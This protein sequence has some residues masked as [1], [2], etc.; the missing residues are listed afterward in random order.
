[1]L[2]KIEQG[3]EFSEERL[4]EDFVWNHLETALDL[5][6][7][8][9][10][11][12]IQGEYCD[13]LAKT[14]NNQ[15]VVLELKNCEDRYIIH[16]LTRY[17][18]GLKTDQPFKDL[19]DYSQ[20]IRLIAIAPDFHKHNFIDRRY[21]LLQIEFIRSV[22]LNQ[23]NHFYLHLHLEGRKEITI[24]EPIPFIEI[25]DETSEQIERNIEPP[26]R[27]LMNVLDD[28]SPS[29]KTEILKLR[30]KILGCD[31]RIRE[32]KEGKDIFYGRG[33]TKP[34]CQLK[35]I[36]PRTLIKTNSLR[37]H[38]WLPIPKSFLRFNRNSGIG[39]MFLNCDS[40]FRNVRTVTYWSPTNRNPTELPL[41]IERYLDEIGLDIANQN[42]DRLLDL[43][44]K[45]NLERS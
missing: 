7:L 26:S 5:I 37:L 8:K 36:S 12:G 35:C 28:L 15:L 21:N 13:I 30:E 10:Q 3:W 25:G 38:L 40:D 17:Y 1:M 45:V 34:C 22:I 43:A 44:I 14:A 23:T 42:L 33:K 24:Q 19:V 4:L 27:M 9:R 16:Q 2:R 18:H 6:P 39:R 20:P 41:P 31:R 32:I 11:Y 29:A